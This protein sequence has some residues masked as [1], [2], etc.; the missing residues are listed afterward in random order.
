MADLHPPRKK[1]RK[2]TSHFGVV[3]L[4]DHHYKGLDVVRNTGN[5]IEIVNI[6]PES[7]FRVNNEQEMSAINPGYSNSLDNHNAGPNSLMGQFDENNPAINIQDLNTNSADT[8]QEFHA[9]NCNEGLYIIYIKMEY[10]ILPIK[11]VR[12]LIIGHFKQSR[13][14]LSF[15]AIQVWFQ[16]AVCIPKRYIC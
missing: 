5:G 1:Y 9:S 2:K 12:A 6:Q 13:W 3:E 16:I 8:T 14:K 7:T 4:E 10:Y 11:H 15:L